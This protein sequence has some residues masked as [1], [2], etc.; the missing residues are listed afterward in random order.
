MNVHRTMATL[1]LAGVRE[2][3]GA[4]RD[5]WSVAETGV[6]GLLYDIGGGVGTTVVYG[7]SGTGGGLIEGW[8]D[9]GQGRAD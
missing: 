5:G 8:T 6:V 1:E 9:Q 3:A 2:T 7:F 4:P